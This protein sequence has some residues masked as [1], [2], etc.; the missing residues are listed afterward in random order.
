MD[1]IR[2]NAGQLLAP[3]ARDEIIESLQRRHCLFRE[4]GDPDKT[5]LCMIYLS[6][7]GHMMYLRGPDDIGSH[8]LYRNIMQP[9][10]GEGDP[11]DPARFSRA[12]GNVVAAYRLR[13][14]V[15][16]RCVRS[17]AYHITDGGRVVARPVGWDA[18]N[19]TIVM[20]PP[21]PLPEVDP[22]LPHL[23][24]L[25]SGLMFVSPEYS[26]NLVG[27][28]VAAYMRS[29]LDEF[30]I[31]AIDARQ[32]SSGK[33]QAAAAFATVVNGPENG[34]SITY[35]GTEHEFE[36]RLG[37][38][39]GQAGPNV[40]HVDN[41]RA[42]QGG[43]T[44]IRSQALSAC[45]HRHTVRVRKLH[46]GMVS[47]HDPVVVLTMNGSRVEGDLAD[48]LVPVSLIRPPGEK[49]HRP[50]LPYPT[51]YAADHR[52]ALCA[53]IE[54]VI[55]KLELKPI[56]TAPSWSRFYVFEQVVMQAAAMCGLSA[57]FDPSVIRTADQT[58]I[59]LIHLIEDN[60]LAVDGRVNL[61]KLS[62]TLQA[63]PGVRELN[64]MVAASSRSVAGRHE[65]LREY[66]VDN[67]IDHT[68]RYR[69]KVYRFSVDN[70]QV[71]V[72]QS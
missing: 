47:L 40:I 41:V 11:Q 38:F 2:F 13:F 46:R 10:S 23:K 28:L 37:T 71:V 21:D 33:T 67:L 42:K 58:V 14:P 51:K 30:P 72:V 18:V 19:R 26:G 65:A 48:K 53:E 15:L 31:I 57:S 16:S 68:Y 25:F 52:L 24:T 44:R 60:K 34:G 9:V 22:T 61:R 8:L 5:T 36:V 62:D 64:E 29:A 17:P 32:K 27:C 56:D 39:A 50:I 55:S 54:Y 1:P 35:S 20:A 66:L 59:E 12:V 63:N 69:D 6:E 49:V 4:E 43:I 70:D 3:A 7:D 45:V